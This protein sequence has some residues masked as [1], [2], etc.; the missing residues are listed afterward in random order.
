MSNQESN[1][2]LWLLFHVLALTP[3]VMDYDHHKPNEPSLLLCCSW[4][5]CFITV[6][7][8]EQELVPT[9]FN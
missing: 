2:P 6:S 7:E 5:E 9:G 1:V 4:L 3:S 8:R